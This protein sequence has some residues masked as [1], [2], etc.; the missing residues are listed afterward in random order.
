MARIALLASHDAHP[1]AP[2]L[3]VVDTGG[4]YPDIPGPQAFTQIGA[5]QTLR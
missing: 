1:H 2:N 4:Q 5:G 3:K